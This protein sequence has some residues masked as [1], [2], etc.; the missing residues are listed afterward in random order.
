MQLSLL[1]IFVEKYYTMLIMRF[2]VLICLC[3]IGKHNKTEILMFF[4]KKEWKYTQKILLFLKIY[5]NIIRNGWIKL[6][7]INKLSTGENAVSCLVCELPTAENWSQ[8]C[9]SKRTEGKNKEFW[10]TRRGCV[11]WLRDNSC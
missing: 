1:Y 10:G 2:L 4:F 11:C 9:Q 7:Y 5:A 8:Q 3:A 6:A